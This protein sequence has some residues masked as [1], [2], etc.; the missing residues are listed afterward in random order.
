MR[1]Y[2][3]FLVPV[4]MLPFSRGNVRSHTLPADVGVDEE[5]QAVTLLS[6]KCPS[7]VTSRPEQVD[8][9]SRMVS[10][11]SMTSLRRGSIGV[12]AG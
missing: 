9:D 2:A 3:S 1:I 4:L 8:L 5:R 6:K 7:V 10:C 12:H 11:S